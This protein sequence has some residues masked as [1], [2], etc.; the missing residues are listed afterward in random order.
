MP[1]DLGFAFRAHRSGSVEIVRQGRVVMVLGGAAAA[2]F[3]ARVEG[4]SP[5]EAQ[6]QM[7]RIT[8]NYRRGNERRAGSHDRNRG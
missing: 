8:G 4:A 2:D 1:D 5:A 6:Q 3:L 7:A